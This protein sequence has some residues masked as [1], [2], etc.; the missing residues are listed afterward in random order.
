MT[1]AR[2]LLIYLTLIGSIANAATQTDILLYR[3]APGRTFGVSSDTAYI[4]DNGNPNAAILA[5][6]FALTSAATICK[7]NW[8][9][10]YGSDFAQSLEPPPSSESFRIRIYADSVGLPGSTLYDEIIADS[11]RVATGAA[12]ATGI[13]PVEYLYSAALPGCFVAQAGE[14]YWLEVSQVGDINS[15]FR[16]ENA[17]IAGGFAQRFPI[18]T[19]WRLSSPNR[20]QLAYE[21]WTPEP[22]SGALLAVGLVLVRRFLA[23]EVRP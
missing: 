1:A 14:P 12:I 2:G 5:D 17:N 6:A 20:G 18:D 16:W 15:L 3:Q 9:G 23:A 11:S 7:L 19:P 22:C 10:F 8:W 13:G 21:L 4:D